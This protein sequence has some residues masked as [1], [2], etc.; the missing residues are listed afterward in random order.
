MGFTL[1]DISARVRAENNKKDGAD[2]DGEAEWSVSVMRLEREVLNRPGEAELLGVMAG[3]VLTAV[4]GCDLRCIGFKEVCRL[5]GES[6]FP[7]RL[8]FQRR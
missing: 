7:R 6:T 5:L 4:N 2:G 1:E 8:R 3:D